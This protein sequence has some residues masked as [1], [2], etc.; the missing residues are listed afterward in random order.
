[1]FLNGLLVEKS[2]KTPPKADKVANTALLR[3]INQKDLEFEQKSK[4]LE[5]SPKKV[6]RSPKKVGTKNIKNV[7]KTTLTK[8]LKKDGFYYFIYL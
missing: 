7:K 3:S 6:E 5:K 8:D 4:K 1:M 2:V